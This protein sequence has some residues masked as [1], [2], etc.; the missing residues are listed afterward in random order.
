MQT[1]PEREPTLQ[2]LEEEVW[3]EGREWMRQRLEEKLQAQADR[4]GQHFPPRGAET[5][6]ATE[7]KADAPQQRRGRGG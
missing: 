7:K 6:A 5:G 2:E 4:I 1:K 3:A